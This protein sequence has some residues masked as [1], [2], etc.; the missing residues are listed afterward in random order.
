MVTV[1]FSKRDLVWFVPLVMIMVVGFGLAYN[2]GYSPEVMGHSAGEVESVCLSDGTN[3]DVDK[4]YVDGAVS[5]G[6]LA[7][8]SNYEL[9]TFSGTGSHSLSGSFT[10]T[11]VIIWRQ[12]DGIAGPWMKTSVD[13]GTKSKRFMD[14]KWNDNGITA[15]GFGSFTTGSETSSGTWGYVAIK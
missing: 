9:G 12:A 10:P 14:S 15:L 11:L 4:A 7:G 6:A 8:I 1:S 2:S 3:C 5:G 13:G